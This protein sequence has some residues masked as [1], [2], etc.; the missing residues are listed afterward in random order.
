MARRGRLF[1]VQDALHDDT[2]RILNL[3]IQWPEL[4]LLRVLP[5]AKAAQNFAHTNQQLRA[6][7][8]GG[9]FDLL[10]RS[11]LNGALFALLARW[12]QRRSDKWWASV[13]YVYFY[14]TCVLTIKYSLFYQFLTFTKIIL[15]MLLL[16]ILLL[17]Y[18]KGILRLIFPFKVIAH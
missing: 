17:R 10:I 8:W 7:I 11:L 9:E 12:F 6:A 3:L 16:A 2:P 1:C 4:L 13:A 5:D 14:S 18:Q 15:P